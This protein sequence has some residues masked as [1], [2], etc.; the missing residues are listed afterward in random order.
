MLVSGQYRA[1][2]MSDGYPIDDEIVAV[3]VVLTW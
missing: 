2:K 1:G 3:E